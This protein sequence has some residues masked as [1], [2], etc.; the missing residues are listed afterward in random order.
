MAV[1]A[2]LFSLSTIKSAALNIFCLVGHL[3]LAWTIYQATMLMIYISL[4]YHKQCIYALFSLVIWF[5]QTRV[6]VFLE[7]KNPR[8]NISEKM[9]IWLKVV[10]LL[11]LVFFLLMPLNEIGHYYD[12]SS[13]IKYLLLTQGCFTECNLIAITVILT[14]ILCLKCLVQYILHYRCIFCW[15]KGKVLFWSFNFSYK[16]LW[17]HVAPQFIYSSCTCICT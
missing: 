1:L 4:Y 14:N 12:H 5:I 8:K 2:I 16:V 17:L 3:N 15:L 11:C 9:E 6:E 7:E 10:L 13:Q